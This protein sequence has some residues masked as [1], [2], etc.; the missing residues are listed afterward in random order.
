MTDFKKEAAERIAAISIDKS[1]SD[2]AAVF[3]RTSIAQ[4]YSYNFAWQGRSIIQYPQDMVAMQ[5]LI[6]QIKPDLIIETG[7]AHGGSLI[8]SASLLAL[9]DMCDAIETGETINPKVSKRKVLGIDID[10]RAHNRVAIEAHPMYSRIQMIEGSSIAPEIISQVKTIA[11]DYSRVLVCLDSNHTH[12][13]VLAELEA[14]A[15]LTSAGSYCVVFDTVVEDMP[16]DMFPDRPWGPGNNPKTAVWEYLR[17]HPEFEID[18]SVQNK[19]LI[20]VA[21]DGFLKKIFS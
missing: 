4:K 12:D 3:M 18:K 8:F 1:R 17:T 15:P 10:I 16:A 14:Y 5:E 20:T 13:H 7:I 21:P 19:L 2:D 11:D 6:W 9:L